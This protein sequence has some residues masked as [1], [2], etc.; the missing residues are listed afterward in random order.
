[1]KRLNRIAWE[2]FTVITLT[3][4]VLFWLSAMG[5]LAFSMDENVDKLPPGTFSNRQ[6]Q[7]ARTTIGNDSSLVQCGDYVGL[8]KLH[9]R[10][11]E[12]GPGLVFVYQFVA[13][14]NNLG[15][16]FGFTSGTYFVSKFNIVV[17]DDKEVPTVEFKMARKF[18][19][20]KSSVTRILVRISKQDYNQAKCLPPASTIIASPRK[21]L[22]VQIILSAVATRPVFLF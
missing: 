22:Y 20:G 11:T 18:L 4:I 10:G 15:P 5:Y 3:S 1:M 2:V 8:K 12:K 19:L 7:L 21:T 14:G 13:G 9:S 16:F 6:Y 17:D